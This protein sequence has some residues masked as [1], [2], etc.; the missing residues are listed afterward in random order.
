MERFEFS[1]YL[2]YSNLE[3]V[4]V[5]ENFFPHPKLGSDLANSHLI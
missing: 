1:Y 3:N 5:P 4:C 2:I